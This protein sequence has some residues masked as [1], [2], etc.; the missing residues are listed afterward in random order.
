MRGD[1]DLVIHSFRNGT[2]DDT[3]GTSGRGPSIKE[4]LDVYRRRSERKEDEGT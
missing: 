3:V 4:A 2:M 1:E